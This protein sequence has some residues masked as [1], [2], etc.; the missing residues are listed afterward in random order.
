MS[1]WGKLIGSGIG[2][3]FGGPLGALIGGVAGHAYDKYK[4]DDDD[5]DQIGFDPRAN[6][7][8]V[9]FTIGV[10]ALGAKMAKADG[11]VTNDEIAAF[12]EV[13]HVPEEEAKN[14]ARVFNTAKRDA[15]GFEP[16]AQQI[17]GMFADAPEVLEDL[18][19]GL[20]HIARAD[21]IIHPKE[22]EFL[23][24][25]ASIFGLSQSAYQRLHATH[26]MPDRNDPYTVL[27][28]DHNA[29]DQEIKAAYRRMIKANHPDRVIA[30]GLPEEF[31]AVANEKLS[32]INAAYEQISRERNFG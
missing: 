10:I 5:A 14:V 16:Y 30:Q 31:V 18:L 29:T 21:N 28:V 20:M 4:G 27:E 26:L 7:K 13:F 15:T 23:Q 22:V 17:A 6:T 25:V 24:A 12:K 32:K 9:A 8:K 11:Q 1:I 19:A 3:A 2:L